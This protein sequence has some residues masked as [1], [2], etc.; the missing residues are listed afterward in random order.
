MI[1]KS[2]ESIFVCKTIIVLYLICLIQLCFLSPPRKVLTNKLSAWSFPAFSTRTQNA[3][4]IGFKPIDDTVAGL[5]FLAYQSARI[6]WGK[7]FGRRGKEAISSS[8][9]FKLWYQ[10]SKQE[11]ILALQKMYCTFPGSVFLVSMQFPVIIQV[12]F[13]KKLKP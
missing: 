12:L 7:I 9:G 10:I 3:I 2:R 13:T 4:R 11:N 6:E 1:I 8:N 5:N